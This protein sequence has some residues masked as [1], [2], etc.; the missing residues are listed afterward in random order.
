M[1]IDDTV[2][3]IIAD[4]RSFAQESFDAAIA[5]TNDA[6][7]EADASATFNEPAFS[8]N[9]ADFERPST[10][11]DPGIFTGQFFRPDSEP[12]RPVFQPIY[13]PDIPDLEAAPTPLDTSNLFTIPRPDFIVP[14]FTDVAPD[15]NTTFDFPESP[16]VVFPDAPV[17]SEIEVPDAP[18]LTL[19]KFGFSF[20]EADPDALGDLSASYEQAFNQAVPQLRAALETQMEVLI[21]RFAPEY[22]TA[23]ARLEAKIEAGMDGG[24]AMSENVEQS[25]FDRARY[26]AEEEYSAAM[27]DMER[28]ISSRGFPMPP[29]L[30]NEL[31]V[32]VRVKMAK[33]VVAAATDV[34]IERARLEQQHAQF[35]MQVSATLRQSMLN[36]MLQYSAQLLEINS[37]ALQFSRELNQFAVE[38]YNLN[39]QRY[40]ALVQ[41][42]R[43]RAE[44]YETELKSALADMQ[45]FELEI[46]AVKLRKDIEQQDFQ[47]Y[48]E[49]I[50][51]QSTKI[52]L[53]R[54][55]LEGVST[56]AGVQ[57]LRIELYGEKVRAHSLLVQ[58][59][60]AEFGAYRSALEGDMAKVQAHAEEVRAYQAR[61]Q[62][63]EAQ[64][65]VEQTRAQ[66]GLES[67]RNIAAVY[68]SDI[69]RYL[70]D[71]DVEKAVFEGD[72]REYL[73]A[74]DKYKTDLAAELDILR[75]RQANEELELRADLSR[76][77]GKLRSAIEK[78]NLR[79]TLIDI[80]ARTSVA[81]ADVL[82]TMAA[83]TLQS[84]NTMV[85]L[86]AT[87]SV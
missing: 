87:E 63:F 11:S 86:V 37:Q 27:K 77:D 10:P 57:R 58:A 20:T 50:R 2:N 79:K 15:I 38:V 46:Q 40:Q 34:A 13:V 75:A 17:Q 43:T 31:T 64:A 36:A 42:Y 19:P 47:I 82:N 24:T 4:S 62:A 56:E 78:A 25:I 65:G 54:A 72:L 22:H 69:R 70:A 30:L 48:V 21:D 39:L 55:Q 7:N 61:V 1:T 28:Q 6:V 26:R 85:Q 84:Q 66:V 74:V 23:L 3:A 68:E 41:V 45:A 32:Q 14:D 29:G 59:K 33:D 51:A 8:A 53:Y 67:N 60:E 12:T 5:L 18:Q 73:A 76:Y 44:V 16:T 80:R 9:I 83:A 49:K 35:I 71:V 52:D 81:A